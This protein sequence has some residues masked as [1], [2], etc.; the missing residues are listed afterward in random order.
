ML[1]QLVLL[2]I[3]SAVTV[4]YGYLLFVRTIRTVHNSTLRNIIHFV[5]H[6]KRIITYVT[7]Q[8]CCLAGFYCII[9]KQAN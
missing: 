1:V 7:V 3:D 6:V 9:I 4:C 2:W 5:Q 8:M